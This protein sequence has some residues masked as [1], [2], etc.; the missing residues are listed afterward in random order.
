VVLSTDEELGEVDELQEEPST[1]DVGGVREP[2]GSICSI[3]SQHSSSDTAV[4]IKPK[5]TLN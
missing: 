3:G 4:R 2:G 1:V 5:Y